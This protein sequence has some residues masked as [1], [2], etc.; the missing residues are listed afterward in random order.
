MMDSKMYYGVLILLV[1]L[2]W[3]ASPAYKQWQEKQSRQGGLNYANVIGILT[4]LLAILFLFSPAVFS[5][6]AIPSA[7][8]A[9]ALL[10]CSRRESL[11]I[12]QKKQE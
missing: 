1:L 10:A 12:K 6:L 8:L 2:A 9:M 5:L 3:I 4:V 7:L 11:K